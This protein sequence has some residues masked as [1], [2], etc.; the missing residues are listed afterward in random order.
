MPNMPPPLLLWLSAFLFCVGIVVILTKRDAIFVLLGIELMLNAA[1]FNF[2]LFSNYD[3]KQQGQV[4]ALLVMAI[5]VCETAVALAI[6]VQVYRHRN[7]VE[8]EKL[9]SLREEV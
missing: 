2:V 3:P 7:S 5:V 8:L 1:N 9:Q 6:I 4:F